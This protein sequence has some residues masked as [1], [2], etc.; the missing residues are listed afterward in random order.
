[1]ASTPCPESDSYTEVVIDYILDTLSSE[2]LQHLLTDDVAWEIIVETTDLTRKEADAVREAL[3]DLQADCD[4]DFQARKRFLNEFPNVKK[5]MQEHIAKLY[6]LAERIDK[7]HKGCTITNVVASTGGAV[8]GIL[9]MLGFALAP[10]TAGGSLVLSATGMGLGTAAAVTGVSASIVDHSNK[11][12]AQAEARQLLT[13]RLD[14][15]KE[16]LQV[17]GQATPKVVAASKKCVQTFQSIEKNLYALKVAQSNPRLLARAN[18]F[19]KT[20]KISAR[21]GKQVQKAFGGTTLAM[22]KGTRLMGAAT[23][24][25]FALVDVYSLVQDSVHLHNGAKTESAA[26][27]RQEA[28]V[29]EEKLEELTEIYESL[30]SGPD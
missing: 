20:G 6:A 27:L 30:Q 17:V 11:V 1:M 14:T 29:L 28:Q 9:T 4:E 24:G 12:S 10:V 25:L 2:D 15:G 7:V 18:R 16:V 5:E 19:I 8:S 13:S 3:T 21:S 26:E 23:A 22:T